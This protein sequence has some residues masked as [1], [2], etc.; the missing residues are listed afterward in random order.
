MDRILKFCLL[1]IF[2]SSISVSC[3][4]KEMF[5]MNQEIPDGYMRLNLNFTAPD[6]ILTGTK[7]V[8][9]DGK[10][11]NKISLYCFDNYGMFISYIDEVGISVD[12]NNTS[13]Y[14][15]KGSIDNVLVP[16]NT[17]R[18]H[19][20]GNQNNTNFNE[21]NFIGKTEKE[22]ISVL[23]SSSGMMVYWGYFAA[24]GPEIT[25][26]AKFEEALKNAHGKGI[27]GSTPIMMLRNQA[28]I[29]VPSVTGVFKVEGF[30][31]INTNAFGTVAPY[32]PEKGFNFSRNPK[33]SD[34]DSGWDP[35]CDWVKDDFISLP[36][37]NTRLSPPQDID[38]ADETC[39]FETNNTSSNPVSI[40]VY[41]KNEG[42][43]E[44]KYFKIVFMT[45]D[46]DYVKIRRNFHYKVNI[47]GALSYGQSSFIDAVNGPASNNIW[48]S[49]DDEVSKISDSNFTL[50]MN[51]THI[52][53]L[54]ELSSDKKWTLSKALKSSVF[55]LIEPGSRNTNNKY[56]LD[57]GYYISNSKQQ[58]TDDDEPEVGWL[59]DCE[60]S[61]L[62]VV[63]DFFNEGGITTPNRA[64]SEVTVIIDNLDLLNSKQSIS[65][66]VYVKKGMLLR[67][68]RITILKAL[69]FTPVWV[70]TQ[71]NATEG[72]NLTLLF[73]VPE[74]TP[75]ELLPFD[76][77]VSASHVD[78]RASSGMILPIITYE[79]DPDIYGN[80]MYSSY[81]SDGKPSGDPIGYKYVYTVTEKGD[82][83]IYFKNIIDRGTAN[84]LTEFITIESPFFKS[85]RKPITFNSSSEYR[86]EMPGLL[87]YNT[88][89]EGTQNYAK[90][91][92]IKYLLVPQKVNAPI[93]LDIAFVKKNNN[94]YTDLDKVGDKDEFLFYSE[95]LMHF[96]GHTDLNDQNRN[97]DC[98]FIDINQELWGSGG[99][100]HAFRFMTNNGIPTSKEK[101]FEGK[102][103]KVYTMKMKTSKAK[104]GE[105]IRISSNQPN[106]AAAF[107]SGNYTGN[108]YRSLIFELAN[109]NPFHFGAKI[110]NSSVENTEGGTIVGGNSTEA[111]D[112]ITLN[113]GPTN[114][115]DATN[116]VDIYFDI[117]SF[118][119]VTDNS[120][121]DPFGT[122]F[123]VYIVAP[124]LELNP[125]Y[126]S[127]KLTKLKDGVFAYRVG[128]TRQFEKDSSTAFSSGTT[129][130]IKDAS[131][132]EN[133][134]NGERKK[135]SFKRKNS[136]TQGEIVLT[137]D[138]KVAGVSDLPGHSEQNVVY[139]DKKFI[140]SNAPITGNITIKDGTEVTNMTEGAFVAFSLTKNNSRIGS[141]KI[142]GGNG[143]TPSRYELIL[144]SEYSF[145]WTDEIEITHS[146]GSGASRETFKCTTETRKGNNTNYTFNLAD[147]F[148]NPNIELVKVN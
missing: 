58:I 90:D 69:S 142:Y 57:L 127:D 79:N 7:A 43:S 17:R 36:Q 68:I 66:T 67:K 103:R 92:Q 114:N 75:D 82:Q 59:E 139:Q 32:H 33:N 130:A 136:V 122:K 25:D 117:T 95:N 64:Y 73:T 21:H 4:R 38:I 125:S 18:I 34:W 23:E 30:T 145:Y 137:T 104:S 29:T 27:N 87:I 93:D 85:I 144:K 111:I 31:V 131:A 120:S 54:A 56:E 41:G 129:V 81:D 110:N 71:V 12:E 35:N 83:R 97:C 133:A 123:Y 65:G 26:A 10:G 52:E 119:S 8:D 128:A 106:S 3:E 48:L 46:G 102:T 89:G 62:P 115:A 53:L 121:V 39:V 44:N 2:A 6:M 55:D 22:V 77:Y 141:M 143:S 19:F 42:E 51:E 140:V 108:G 96:H 70:S 109:Y 1:I 60:I 84:A 13:E 14:N 105:V 116:N 138:P 74:E 49:I 148:A 16:E 78:V 28:R 9:P 15:L 107:Y 132:G 20:L 134:Q 61:N 45:N 135:I 72:E 146:H 94:S 76:V 126:N 147:L 88:G 112:N 91:E 80:D 124:M 37:N 98:E 47:K 101:Q 50:E 86:I 118:K 99:K 63:N 40:I 11:V 24:Y 100:V 113:Y 5:D